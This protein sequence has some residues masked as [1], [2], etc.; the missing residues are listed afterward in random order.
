MHAIHNKKSFKCPG[1]NKHDAVM[2]SLR[3]N[4]MLK[5]YGLFFAFM[6]GYGSAKIIESNQYLLEFLPRCIDCRAV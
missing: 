5:Q 1:G 6:F 3:S 2:R 4:I